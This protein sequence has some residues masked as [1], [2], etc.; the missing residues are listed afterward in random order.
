M[1]DYF[2]VIA[3]QL[4]ITLSKIISD[5][6]NGKI[7]ARVLPNVIMYQDIPGFGNSIWKYAVDADKALW[8][9]L[10]DMM[11]NILLPTYLYDE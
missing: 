4:R 2:L 11:N 7:L 9:P 1:I 8:Y 5:N 10:I 3:K 6:S